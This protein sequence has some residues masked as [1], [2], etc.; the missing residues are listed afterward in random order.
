MELSGTAPVTIGLDL[1]PKLGIAI[2]GLVATWQ[3]QQP[4]EQEVHPSDIPQPNDSPEG[5]DIQRH[6]F[7]NKV[8]PTIDRNAKIPTR[9]LCN[10]KESIIKLETKD[11]DAVINRRQY[12]IPIA[13]QQRVKEQVETWLRDGVV[14][15]VT[16]PTSWNSPITLAPKKDLFG[17]YTDKRPCLDPRHINR[18]LVEPD[19]HPLPLINDIYAE[20]RG[21]KVFTTLDLKSAFHRFEIYEPDRPKTAFKVDGFPQLMFRG[22]P[23][24]LK[25]ISS[26]FQR[27]MD[28]V[29]AEMPFVKTFVDD[30]IIFSKNIEEHADHVAAAINKLTS[31][32]LILNPQ[33]CHFAQK[34]VYLLGFCISEHKKSLDTRK[35]TNVQ[36]W[37]TPRTGK[38]IQRFLGVINYFR[39]HIPKAADLMAP[40]DKLRN[41]HRLG[42][43][44]T[45]RAEQAFN[46]LK[47][48]LLE[49]PVLC[50]P[51]LNH[52][53]QV[54]TDASNTG[55]GAVLYQVING[56]THHIGFMA[57]SLSRSERNYSTTKRELLAIVFALNKFHKYLWENRQSYDDRMAGN[58]S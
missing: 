6:I 56:K 17:N 3:Q 36:D 55:I 9:S 39:E 20:L 54:A 34:A 43:L 19:R 38:D 32:N 7:F 8:Q 5:S 44:W 35:V 47:Q 37:P 23:F 21:S 22:C 15:R 2:T 27:T 53:F 31:V 52:P 10:V 46:N 57:R 4:K 11:A 16:K 26:T 49:A 29:F 41:A 48:I 12:P 42:R 13:S 45:P 18:L 24:G 28:I 50:H 30:I 25:P 40:L 58:H 14:E 51:D 1:M 33:K